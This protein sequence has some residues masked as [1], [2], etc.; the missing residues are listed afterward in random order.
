MNTIK[1]DRFQIGAAH[2]LQFCVNRNDCEKSVACGCGEAT[3]LLS[4]VLV[5]VPQHGM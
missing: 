3:S 4:Q 5:N 2:Q 1:S